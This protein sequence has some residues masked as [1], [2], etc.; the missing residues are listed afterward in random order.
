MQSPNIKKKLASLFTIFS[1]GV[2]QPFFNLGIQYPFFFISHQISYVDLIFFAFLASLFLPLLLGSLL[3]AISHFKNERLDHYLFLSIHFILGLSSALIIVN[4]FFDPY[5]IIYLTIGSALIVSLIYI[6]LIHRSNTF[7]KL[8]VFLSPCTIIFL[9]IFLSNS[10]LNKHLRLHSSH[11]NTEAEKY[12][13]KNIFILVFDE[14][15]TATLLNNKYEIDKNHFPNFYFLAS[16]ANWYRNA[17]TVA[18]STKDSIPAILSGTMPNYKK[19]NK[20]YKNN[21]LNY[22]SETHNVESFETITNL[23]NSQSINKH[24]PPFYA[25]HRLL[26]IDSMVVLS[27][28]ISPFVLR[29]Y[30]PNISNNWTSFTNTGAH[31]RKNKKKSEESA[32]DRIAHFEHFVTKIKENMDDDKPSFY[33]IHSKLPHGHWEYTPTLKKYFPKDKVFGL[34]WDTQ[35]W[36]KDAY[37]VLQ[38]YQR[39]LLQT[40]AVDTLLGKFIGKLKEIKD[41]DQSLIIVTA[42]HGA[43]FYPEESMRDT[44]LVSE[45]AGILGIPLFVKFPGQSQGKII[46]KNVQSIDI[47]PTISEL[48]GIELNWDHAGISL[49]AKNQ[50]RSGPKKYY[51][52]NWTVSGDTPRNKLIE[53]PGSILESLFKSVN[54][55]LKFFP[56]TASYFAIHNASKIKIGRLLESFT[57]ADGKELSITFDQ[58]YKLH[59]KFDTTAM[60]RIVGTIG[61]NS[62]FNTVSVAAFIDNKL[63]AIAPLTA[64]GEFS[65][66]I[67]EISEGPT[68]RLK[69]FAVQQDESLIFISADLI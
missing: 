6:G 23:A 39:H 62:E 33:F 14:L 52:H 32:F 42:D 9:G 45:Q 24:R 34:H 18:I 17:T 68:K 38:G 64:K 40:M 5:Q 20:V 30:L 60:H 12:S 58:S 44:S 4:S 50:K 27:H 31:Q 29:R 69:L 57:I 43:N 15:P 8:T 48:I 54:Y 35:V 59:K 47:T 67:P 66:I 25:R 26:I 46:D 61:R 22:Y 56:E 13:K 55:K 28:M 49:I 36:G 41:F 3:I 11:A 7:F 63:Q 1:F 19:E 53:I 2:L 51:G 65:L 21:I 16:K 37:Y 10:Q